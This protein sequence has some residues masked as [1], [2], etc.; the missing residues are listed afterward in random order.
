MKTPIIISLETLQKA[1]LTPN[2]YI[3][4]HCLY[5]NI[6]LPKYP[7]DL[8]KLQD[9]KYIKMANGKIWPRHYN[10]K[11][12]FN[13]KGQKITDKTMGDEWER[14]LELYPK[15]S[16]GRALHNKSVARP[17]FIR[18]LKEHSIEDILTGLKNENKARETAKMRGDFFPDPKALS[19]WLNQKTFLDYLDVEEEPETIE[20][21][22]NI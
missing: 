12:L 9:L 3:F 15:K 2:E 4:L 13:T 8:I 1:S 6:P 22:E 21:V 14:L 19:V 20:K 5:N 7:I 16:H 18:V 10:L 17:K 11:K